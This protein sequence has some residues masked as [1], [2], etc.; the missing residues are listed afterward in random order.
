MKNKTKIKKTKASIKLAKT[1]LKITHSGEHNERSSRH[2]LGILF[3]I[4]MYKDRLKK[5]E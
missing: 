4:R 2:S 1:I 3:L 5:L